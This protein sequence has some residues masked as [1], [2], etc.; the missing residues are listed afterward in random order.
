MKIFPYKELQFKLIDSQEETLDRLTRRTERSH[1]LVSKHTSKSFIGIINN[2]HFELITSL[3][4][5]GALCKM[6]GTI[7]KEKGTV[8]I[9][10]N[11]AFQVL[12]GIIL[13]APILIASFL[14]I[15]GPEEPIFNLIILAIVHMI[16]MRFV[17]LGG[18]FKF[19]SKLSL[20]SLRDV[21]DVEWINN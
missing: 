2:N 13:I 16:F 6:S 8:R 5:F 11:S 4:G 18:A 7:L 14:I 10:V 15:S 17:F 19:L 1:S 12:F 20:S 21:L 3:I 9:E